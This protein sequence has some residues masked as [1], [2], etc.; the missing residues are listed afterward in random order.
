MPLRPH[1]RTHKGFIT[2][3]ILMTTLSPPYCMEAVGSLNL[4]NYSMTEG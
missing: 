2:H 4:L 1:R 3:L